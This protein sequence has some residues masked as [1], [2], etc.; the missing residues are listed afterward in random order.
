MCVSYHGLWGQ[1]QGTAGQS[2]QEHT[3]TDSY[4]HDCKE[5]EKKNHMHW[6]FWLHSWNWIE[7]CSSTRQKNKMVNTHTQRKHKFSSQLLAV[8]RDDL[9][10][11]FH[12]MA[13]KIYSTKNY[14]R[15]NTWKIMEMVF[16]HLWFAYN[17]MV[18]WALSLKQQLYV[19]AMKLCN[20]KEETQTGGIILPWLICWCCIY[21]GV[22]Q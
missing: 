14:K 11:L 3:H 13:Q 9:L 12:I 16:I 22:W 1:T 4:I 2:S 7:T 5:R 17:L 10:I 19:S 15:I 18:N 20:A 8:F 21:L 6:S